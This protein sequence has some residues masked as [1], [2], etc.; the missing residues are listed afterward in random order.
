M[1]AVGARTTGV[2]RV[3]GHSA[4][5]WQRV[6]ERARIDD[7]PGRLV[8]EDKGAL[9]DE[10]AVSAVDVVVKV[11]TANAGGANPHQD[12]VCGDLRSLDFRGTQIAGTM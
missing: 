3:N 1:A 6:C 11:R 9:W 5:C 8:P 4:T 7:F 2:G 12:F 10:I